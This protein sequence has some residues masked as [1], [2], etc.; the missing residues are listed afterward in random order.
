MF[1]KW[2]Y[3]F[4][5]G[6]EALSQNRFRALLTSLGIIFGVA[7]VIAMLAIGRGAQEEILEQMQLLGAD[8]I[9]ISPVVEQEEGE[10]EEEEGAN[11]ETGAENRG[12]ERFTPGLNL[13]DA[14]SLADIPMVKQ[15]SPEVVMESKA[16]RSGRETKH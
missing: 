5:I 1:K 4:R 6:L 11:E 16:I 15:V 10:L 14:Y 2:S 12:S 3:N 9:I 7:S 8:N 13:L